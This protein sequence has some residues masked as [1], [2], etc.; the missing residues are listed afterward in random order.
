M[1]LGRS[2]RVGKAGRASGQPVE[3]TNASRLWPLLFLIGPD[4]GG[5]FGTVPEADCI[6]AATTRQS[7]NIDN[8]NISTEHLEN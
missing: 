4:W 7:L 8:L 5:P 2:F 6:N 1:G 3:A